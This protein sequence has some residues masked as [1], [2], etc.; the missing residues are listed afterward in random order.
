MSGQLFSQAEKMADSGECSREMIETETAKLKAAV[1]QFAARLDDRRE[2]ILH[3][4][5]FYQ[6]TETVSRSLIPRI[7]SR[8]LIPRISSRSLIPRIS[9][10]SLIPR[11]SSRSLIPRISSRSLIPRI[12]RH[13]LMIKCPVVGK[14]LII[15]WE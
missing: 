1:H 4:F 8:S 9:S 6:K 12:S 14:Q 5:E 10:R 2:I 11:I 3:A 13:T 7:S 15:G